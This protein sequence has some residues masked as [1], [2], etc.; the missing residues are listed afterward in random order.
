[1]AFSHLRKVQIFSGNSLTK[2][3]KCTHRFLQVE[4]G[5]EDQSALNRN[6]IMLCELSGT[7]ELC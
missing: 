1:M 5:C 4:A 3:A 7:S 2:L 6:S